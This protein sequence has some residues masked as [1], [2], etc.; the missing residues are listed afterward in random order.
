MDGGSSFG[1]GVEGEGNERRER[2]GFIERK[3]KL[4]TRYPKVVDVP[5]LGIIHHR[6]LSSPS[7]LEM[8]L[9][10]HAPSPLRP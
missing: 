8:P 10:C 1:I 7:R 6:P 9:R 3:W 2:E 5:F 4:H